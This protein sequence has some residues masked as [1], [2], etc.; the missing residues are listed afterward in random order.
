MVIDDT[1]EVIAQLGGTDEG[2][3]IYDSA[4][5]TAVSI[6]IKDAAQL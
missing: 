2:L 3:L 1:G 6:P 5:H 4:L